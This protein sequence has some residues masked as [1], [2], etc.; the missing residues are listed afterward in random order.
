MLGSGAGWNASLSVSPNFT[1]AMGL[2]MDKQAVPPAGFSSDV[3][4]MGGIRC[5]EGSQQF[6]GFGGGGAGCK[7]G[8]GG[9]GFV[10]KLIA[11]IV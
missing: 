2:L 4:W 8:G 1:E 11:F 6:G 3:S 10:G 9:G 7:G 5:V